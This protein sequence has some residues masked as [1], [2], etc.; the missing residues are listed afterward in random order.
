MPMSACAA[1][2]FNRMMART[3]AKCGV[4]AR[5]WF[6]A[7]WMFS[8]AALAS[9]AWQTAS[10]STEKRAMIRRPFRRFKTSRRCFPHV[11]RAFLPPSWHCRDVNG[12]VLVDRSLVMS[13]RRDRKYGHW[14]YRKQIRLADGRVV[15]IF[16]VPTTIGL[17]DTKAGAE[18]A[19]RLHL[20]R[21]LKT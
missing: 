10:L 14:L 12:R 3:S 7:R 6:D 13:V 9:L 15:R 4:I 21:V 5:R 18:R 8:R 19:E 20:D 11:R 16:G 2:A 1:G 17:P